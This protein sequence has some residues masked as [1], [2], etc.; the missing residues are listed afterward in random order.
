MVLLSLFNT[1]I[2]LVPLF[3]PLHAEKTPLLPSHVMVLGE[4]KEE[5]LH[6][7]QQNSL[8]I[9]NSS[10]DQRDEGETIQ[11]RLCS[12]NQNDCAPFYSLYLSNSDK[13]SIQWVIHTL[14]KSN[15][16]KLGIKQKE[17]RK[18]GDKI[19]HV[20]PLRFWSFVI[21]EGGLRDDMHKIRKS[22]YKWS[23]FSDNYFKR[24]SRE[25]DNN[26]LLQYVPGFAQSLNVDEN[27]IRTFIQNHDWNGFVNY[28]I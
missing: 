12:S 5:E 24:L 25:A 13:D 3:T 14:A 10:C 21:G 23:N 8:D 22:G 19:E 20:H 6:H 16:V 4:L 1:L 26:N 18:R 7:L 11:I 15:P 27:V 28:F 2:S 17:I 9:F